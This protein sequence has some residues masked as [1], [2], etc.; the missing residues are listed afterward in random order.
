MRPVTRVVPC[1]DIKE[2]RVV[3]GV[4]FRDLTDAGDPATRAA[5]YQ[6]QG[7]DEIVLLDI[8]ATPEGR[9]HGIE[10]VERVRSRLSIPL[11][12]GGGVRTSDDA[13]RLLEAGADKVGVNT[14]AVARPELIEEIA[15]TF[16]S[17]CTV[18]AI[19][20]ARNTDGWSVIVESG[21]VA[22]TLPAAE[23]A[24]TASGLGAGEILLTSWDRDGT[25]HGYDLELLAEVSGAVSVPVVASGGASGPGD[26]VRAV[27]AGASAVLVASLLHFDATTVGAI[28]AEM[29][30]RG[31]EVR[32]C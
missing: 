3:K 27:E 15:G 24:A 18:V 12:V 31:V 11:T 4:R 10:T 14:A 25:G 26:M 8:S 7:A 19:D 6:D 28:K 9:S 22:T 16:G 32:P 29:T 1:L 20:A 2:G 23:W 13:G 30:A 5:L 21:A 17:Q